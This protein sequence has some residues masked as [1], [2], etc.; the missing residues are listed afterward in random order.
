MI[1]FIEFNFSS[2][3]WPIRLFH[4][5]GGLLFEGETNHPILLNVLGAIWGTIEI[6]GLIFLG[7]MMYALT[8]SWWAAVPSTL[9]IYIGYLL[10]GSLIT[11]C[12][13]TIVRKKK[14]KKIKEEQSS[15]K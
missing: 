6:A 10:I 5:G 4:A 12:V 11:F 14:E 13:R 8:R 3:F 2:V 7:L 1:G 15:D 9:G